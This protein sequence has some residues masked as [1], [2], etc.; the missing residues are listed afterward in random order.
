MA[1]AGALAPVTAMTLADPLAYTPQWVSSTASGSLTATDTGGIIT[2]T[3]TPISIEPPT[4]GRL[5]LGRVA[6]TP[7]G[8]VGQPV[9]TYGPWCSS[10]GPYLINGYVDVKD[11]TYDDTGRLTSLAADLSLSCSKSVTRPSVPTAQL[12]LASTV[13]YVSLSATSPFGVA[14]TGEAGNVPVTFT[15]DGSVTVHPGTSTAVKA[16]PDDGEAVITQDGC[17]GVTLDPGQSCQVTIRTAA[18]RASVHLAVPELDAV[19]AYAG[20]SSIM[21][22]TGSVTHYAKP[23]Q[24]TAVRSW[25][26]TDGVGLA[27]SPAGLGSYAVD[28]RSDAGGWQR[29]AE[30]V[31]VSQYADT[32]APAGLASTYRITPVDTVGEFTEGAGESAPATPLASWQPPKAAL[33][34]ASVDGNGLLGAANV[35]A[36]R[37]EVSVAPGLYFQAGIRIFAPVEGWRPGSFVVNPSA[38]VRAL[39]IAP[40]DPSVWVTGTLTVSRAVLRADGGPAEFA[41]VLTGTRLSGTVTVPV[42]AIVV[43]GSTPTSLPAYVVAEPGWI[44]APIPL[45]S[46]QTRAVA[47]RNVG[48]AAGAVTQTQ[49][50]ST[51]SSPAQF[52]AWSTPTTCLNVQIPPAGRCTTTVR[53]RYETAGK[54]GYPLAAATWRGAGGLLT[55]VQ[56]SGEWPNSAEQP[57]L[58]MTAPTLVRTAASLTLKASDP[59]A[60]EALQTHCRLDLGAFVACVSPWSLTGLSNGQHTVTAYVTDQAGHMSAWQQATIIA[61]SVG[62]VTSMASP[63]ALVAVDYPV[64]VSWNTTDPGVGTKSV[65]ARVRTASPATTYGRYVVPS[66]CTASISNAVFVNPTEGK[67]QC[68]SARAVDQFNQWG[69]WSSE[70]CFL[71]PLDDRRLTSRGFFRE[72]SYTYKSWKSTAR[73]TGATLKLA[74]VRARQV[75]LLVQKCSTCGSLDVYVGSTRL[76]RVNTS[77]ATSRTKVVVWLPRQKVER[78]GTLVIRSTSSKRVVVDGVLV[79]HR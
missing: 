46:D 61:D 51:F 25:P 59:Q 44:S 14:Y 71:A 15:N 68:W 56:L 2:N 13:P 3:Y 57:T 76:G 23:A 22:H 16:N 67:E 75:G 8:A 17:V 33:T 7:G 50:V 58:S 52:P 10:N 34:Y 54:V 39:W 70:R 35:N 79:R 78:R 48:G 36:D 38:A 64:F 69:A 19:S 55:S 28:R 41:A 37:D 20:T 42:R 9:V 30:S 73:K 26:A 24:V 45:G 6:L 72:S 62:P 21:T 32:S 4:E 18:F 27:W 43:L 60:G 12:R 74:N 40:D 66:C 49:V 53:V 11:V 1:Q 63:T 77:A 29:I 65:Q 47:L 5:V 31:N